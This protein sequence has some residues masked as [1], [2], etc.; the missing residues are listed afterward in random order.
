MT[1]LGEKMKQLRQQQQMSQEELAQ[2]LHVTRQA[3]WKWEHNQSMPDLDNLVRLSELF[4]VT[5]D[6]LLKDEPIPAVVEPV[7]YVSQTNNE[8]SKLFDPGFYIGLL[9]ILIGIFF[10][11]G[12]ASAG[13]I[14]IGLVL[15]FFIDEG[16]QFVRSSISSKS[17]R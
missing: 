6:Y 8:R 4:D 2:Q 10:F 1:T 17:K 9:F 5:T 13:F 11:D 3:V 16:M 12:S 7:D 15:M 14:M